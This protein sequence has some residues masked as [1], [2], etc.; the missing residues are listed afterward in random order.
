MK[1]DAIIQAVQDFETAHPG[2]KAGEIRVSNYSLRSL[3]KQAG[4]EVNGN[5]PVFHAEILGRQVVTDWL[6]P[7]YEIKV[8]WGTYTYG[9]SVP[10]HLFCAALRAWATLMGTELS[11]DSEYTRAERKK[12]REACQIV[13]LAISKSNLLSRMLE[14]GD[15]LRTIPCPI[16]KGHWSGCII[17]MPPCV[18]EEYPFGCMDGMNVTGWLPNPEVVAHQRE[19]LADHAKK[20]DAQ[21]EHE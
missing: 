2:H 5:T 13:D 16:H 3:L 17:D 9:Q 15:G 1:L 8:E 20:D 10:M 19:W 21:L 6:L 18:T 12:I 7:D 11:T 14:G 4:R